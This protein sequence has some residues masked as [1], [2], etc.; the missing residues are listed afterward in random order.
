MTRSAVFAVALAVFATSCVTQSTW[1]PTV[2]TYGDSR[3]QYVSR[4]MEECRSL[5][6]RASGDTTAETGKGAVV[7]GLI[8]AAAGAAIGAAFGSPGTGAAVGAAAGGIGTGLTKGVRS[9]QNFK[10]AYRNCM[11]NRGHTV[12]D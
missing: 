6:T 5:A 7:G 1:T 11:R 8:G 2:D 9:E 3:A 12:I 10:Q 4:D